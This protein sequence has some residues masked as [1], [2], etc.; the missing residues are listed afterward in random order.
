MGTL[1]EIFDEQS[2]HTPCGCIAQAWTIAET[3]RAWHII[4]TVF[5]YVILPIPRRR[6]HSDPPPACLFDPFPKNCHSE[7]TPKNLC[8]ACRPHSP[9][10]SFDGPCLSFA[11]WVRMTCSL[12]T[13]AFVYC[14]RLEN[15]PLRHPRHSASGIHLNFSFM[16]FLSCHSYTYLAKSFRQKILIIY[17]YI[18]VKVG[19]SGI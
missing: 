7:A 8:P 5:T 13:Y 18:K 3:L 17:L 10:R 4:L 19:Y 6:C 11:E 14:S 9:A 15:I 1:A 16:E 12:R 2:P